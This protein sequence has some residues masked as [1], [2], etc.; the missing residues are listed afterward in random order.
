MY[1]N[2]NE[3][4]WAFGDLSPAMVEKLKENPFMRDM[5]TEASPFEI[6]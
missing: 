1:P 5:F 2:E 4:K 3:Y 6:N